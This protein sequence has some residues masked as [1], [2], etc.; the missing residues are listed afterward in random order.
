[1]SDVEKLLQLYNRDAEDITKNGNVEGDTH[2]IGFK[3]QRQ[4]NG[5]GKGL[6]SLQLA[7]DQEK[8]YMASTGKIKVLRKSWSQPATTLVKNANQK[9]HD[10]IHNFN[11]HIGPS[12]YT[13]WRFR[14]NQWKQSLIDPIPGSPHRTIKIGKRG[15]KRDIKYCLREPFFVKKQKKKFQPSTS[16]IKGVTPVP[17]NMAASQASEGDGKKYYSPIKYRRKRPEPKNFVTNMENADN[18]YHR[19]HREAAAGRN[20]LKSKIPLLQQLTEYSYKDYD[21]P[22]IAFQKYVKGKS[23]HPTHKVS[24][25]S[26]PPGPRRKAQ[27]V[28]FPDPADGRFAMDRQYTKPLRHSASFGGYFPHTQPLHRQF[29]NGDYHSKLRREPMFTNWRRPEKQGAA[30]R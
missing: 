1:M 15:S 18:Q 25:L 10:L 3:E 17:T 9:M 21:E 12:T 27:Q 5:L 16:I 14:D 8:R 6:H 13:D 19:L 4:Y 7:L 11:C 26:P 2:R 23:L 30:A 28:E 29:V 22:E 20:I 24:T